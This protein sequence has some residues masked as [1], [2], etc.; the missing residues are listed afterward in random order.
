METELRGGRRKAD[1]EEEEEEGCGE[2]AGEEER[3][4]NTALLHAKGRS[5]VTASV[6]ARG[7]VA[8]GGGGTGM[9]RG[10][11]QKLPRG[12]R[13]AK[14]GGLPGRVAG[15]FIGAAAAAAPGATAT[16]G[17]TTHGGQSSGRLP[18]RRCWA[19]RGGREIYL[20]SSRW[21]GACCQ[22]RWWGKGPASL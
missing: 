8:K 1:E 3:G 4:T 6:L 10:A 5:G 7:A 22:L 21:R 16:A 13:L 15:A 20:I 17:A 19:K 14:K 11:A 18:C 2:H 12:L 9:P